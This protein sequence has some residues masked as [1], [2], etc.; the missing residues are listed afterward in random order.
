ML[1]CQSQKKIYQ[2]LKKNFS[3]LYSDGCNLLIQILIDYSIG[4]YKY[5]RFVGKFLNKLQTFPEYSNVASDIEKLQKEDGNILN[6]L[7]QAFGSSLNEYARLQ[8]TVFKDSLIS[9]S[10]AQRL[11][12]EVMRKL[13]SS[14]SSLPNDMRQLNSY[15]D[16]IL[17]KRKETSDLQA[18]LDKYEK[19]VISS[20]NELERAQKTSMSS[21]IKSKIQST[22]ESN[23]QKRQAAFEALESQKKQNAEFEVN[24]R[25]MFLQI[26]TAAFESYMNAYARSMTQLS[27]ACQEMIEK[28]NQIDISENDSSIQDLET[29]LQLLEAEPIDD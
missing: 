3:M 1:L 26:I 24:Y 23:C 25:K 5:M 13:F 9:F 22:Y 20:R 4:F 8:E 10:D 12:T 29:R 21:S 19:A 16:D 11:E 18:N 6:G 15:H 27:N 28:S 7:Q 2:K 14:T 17:K